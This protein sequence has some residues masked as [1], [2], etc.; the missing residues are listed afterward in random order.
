MSFDVINY[1]MDLFLGAKCYG[2]AS[3]HV[4]DVFAQGKKQIL[5]LRS[6]AVYVEKRE[7]KRER[8]KVNATERNYV[9]QS[10]LYINQPPEENP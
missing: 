8:K 4:K 2:F 7:K 10:L 6:Y 1:G 5:L 3:T 9:Q